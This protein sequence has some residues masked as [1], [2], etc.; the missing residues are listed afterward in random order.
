MMMMMMMM[1]MMIISKFDD[2][3]QDGLGTCTKLQA[4]LHVTPSAKP[5][6]RPKRPVPYAVAK[7][8]DNE[9][10]RL[11]DK[12]VIKS[13]N[14]SSWAAPIV[15]V[16]K[17]NGSIRI[18]ADFS[19]GLNAA[20]E[21]HQYPLPL[22]EDIFAKMN[23][24]SHFAKLDLSDA[25]LQIEV[26]ED[27]RELL[28]INTHRGLFQYTRLPFGVKTAPAIFQQVMDTM[29]SGIEGVASYLDDIIIM[30]PS[31]ATLYQ[32]LESV[33]Q[34]IREYGFRVKAEKCEFQLNSVKFLGF[35]IDKNGRRPDPSNL[36]AIIRMPPPSD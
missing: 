3:F 26:A 34:R 13:V 21:S 2:V 31:R 17:S 4:S 7:V 14:Y 23:G 15:V 12:G 29:L 36:D 5:I 33:L 18:C 20:L 25:Y 19:T 22:P 16:K 24:G 1:M 32:R 11:E 28:T 30:G 27:S 6:F 8:V 10:K 35:I 9:L